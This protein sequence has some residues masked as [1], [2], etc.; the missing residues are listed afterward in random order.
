MLKLSVLDQSPRAAGEPTE[1]ALSNTV[2]LARL[3]DELGYSRFWVSEHHDSLGLAGSSPE[4]LAAWIAAQTKRIRVGTGGVMLPHY[5]AYK[6]AENFRVLSGLAPGRIDLGVGRAPGG[7]PRATRALQDGRP[8]PSKDRFPDQVDELYWYLHDRLPDSHP[9]YGLT[10]TP[11]IGEH[12]ELW[13]LGSSS[14]SAALAAYKGLPYNFALFINSEFAEENMQHYLNQFQAS[15]TLSRPE[16]MV[17]VFAVCA[18]TDEEAEYLAGS[19]DLSML[20]LAQGIMR[21]GTP[22][23]D[24]I[25]DQSF[26][27]YER[28]RIMY[29]RRRM[30]IGSPQTIG[31][32]LA[33][34]SERFHVNEI[35]L[36]TIT[37]SFEAKKKSFELIAKEIGLNFPD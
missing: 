36:T 32:H 2:E 23:P 17:T 28:E 18:Q 31:R 12:P 4:I 35:M 7:M 9:Y 6:V 29:N 25:L 8:I 15:E 33:E 5:S 20:W 21:E 37:H 13:M 22:H 1:K 26:S 16:G 19:L 3:A 14:S 27:I 34:L 24:E 30:I 11:V 10:A